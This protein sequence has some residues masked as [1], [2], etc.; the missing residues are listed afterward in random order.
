MS[1]SIFCVFTVMLLYFWTNMVDTITVLWYSYLN[2]QMLEW[3]PQGG[4]EVSVSGGAQESFRCRTK[5]YWGNMAVGGWL[6]WVI[7]MVFS[8]N[9]VSICLW[10]CSISYHYNWYRSTNVVVNLQ[11]SFFICFSGD[12][13]PYLK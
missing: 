2:D 8:N 13:G 9:N 5:G 12:L 6:D 7:F 3:N 11:G 1:L 4:G 10:F